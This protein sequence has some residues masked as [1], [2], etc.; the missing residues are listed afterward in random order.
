MLVNVEAHSARNS[1][2][3]P[4]TAGMRERDAQQC[5]PAA[6]EK[7]GV[8][9]LGAEFPEVDSSGS[10]TVWCG[11]DLLLARR[12][13]HQRSVEYPDFPT[14]TRAMASRSC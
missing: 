1:I 10:I 6:T 8:G 9:V 4:G 7:F 3:C 5:P 11:L 13:L 2:F 14:P 12:A